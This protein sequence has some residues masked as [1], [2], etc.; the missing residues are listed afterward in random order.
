MKHSMGSKNDLKAKK[1]V[2]RSKE[3]KT[4]KKAGKWV[5]I[6]KY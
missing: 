1:V 6:K 5:L 3:K 2:A 4:P